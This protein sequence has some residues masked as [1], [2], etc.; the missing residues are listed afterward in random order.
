MIG[1]L[2]C[3]SAGI[4]FEH[5]RLDGHT[6]LRLASDLVT[7]VIM[8][9][10]QTI[11]GS[12][13]A[14]MKP[15]RHGALDLDTFPNKI[16]WT[17]TPGL[18][19]ELRRAEARLSDVIGSTQ[20]ETLDFR[21]FGKLGIVARDASPDGFV[22]LA[23]QLAY[24]RLYGELRTTYETAMTKAFRHG[25]TEPVRAVT[26]EMW[27]FVR[28][29]EDE[30]SPGTEAPAH[31]DKEEALRRALREQVQQTRR[32]AQGQG[33]DRHLF[34]LLSL[35]KAEDKPVPRLF[36]SEAWR[37]INENILSTSNCGNPSL[38]MF[39]FGAVCDRGIGI[40]Y[41]IRDESLTFCV[42]TWSRQ[43]GRYV[44]LL[45][46]SLRE[47]LSTLDHHADASPAPRHDLP[48][49]SQRLGQ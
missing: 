27:S 46:R 49:G 14:V 13:P 48:P 23:F 8:R 17:L 19:R 9:F 5:S 21:E 41:L 36:E 34:A 10:A 45:E 47:M 26:A 31:R 11:R 39:G 33:F 30:P 1:W 18:R 12:I 25:R 3:R 7:D 15:L 38:R 42:S 44:Q 37:I 43:A 16:R 4:N 28:A 29:F 32:A 24:Y 35:A 40:G 20:V 2:R 22:Q 6:V